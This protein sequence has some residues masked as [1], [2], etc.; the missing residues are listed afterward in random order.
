MIFGFQTSRMAA[1]NFRLLMVYLGLP[2]IGAR[3]WNPAHDHPNLA[4]PI[5]RRRVLGLYLIR[6]ALE[7]AVVSRKSDWLII[8]LLAATWPYAIWLIYR[9]EMKK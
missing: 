1:E 7:P 6:S 4:L 5:H 3:L 2:M 9:A 8:A